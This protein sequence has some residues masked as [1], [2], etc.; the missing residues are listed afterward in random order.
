M[1]IL[2][3]G[4]SPALDAHLAA[5]GDCTDAATRLSEA[6]GL[7]RLGGTASPIP[8][9]LN[10]SSSR[11]S[12]LASTMSSWDSA[13]A[14]LVDAVQGAPA[15]AVSAIGAIAAA[16]ALTVGVGVVPDD[17]PAPTAAEIH[18]ADLSTRAF[19][20]SPPPFDS[21][22]ERFPSDLGS[23]TAS[24][25]GG[26]EGYDDEATTA[27]EWSW[28]VPDGPPE[29]APEA[30]RCDHQQRPEGPHG[31]EYDDRS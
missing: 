30:E 12:T 18:T 13:P 6:T 23:L 17:G 27:R 3:E 19:K 9:A 2:D 15:A 22:A 25:P 5:C 21:V 4:G 28:T 8:E 16:T 29:P 26:R 14:T 7:L 10:A 31:T 11:F 24:L 1:P 20:P